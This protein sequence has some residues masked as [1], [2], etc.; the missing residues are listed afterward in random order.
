MLRIFL[1]LGLL[2]SLFF[3]PTLESKAGVIVPCDDVSNPGDGICDTDFE[4]CIALCSSDGCFW[5]GNSC[6][7]VATPTPTPTP[8]PEPTGACCTG[9]S[10]EICTPDVILC[11]C[12]GIFFDDTSCEPNPCVSPTPDPGDGGP[13]VIVPTMTGW[14]MIFVTII[15]GVLAVIGLRRKGS[16]DT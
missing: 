1:I 6:E 13:L 15:L 14:G 16:Q 2:C 8:T 11:G 7:P 10:N 4:N 3:I 12:E 9:E 5:D